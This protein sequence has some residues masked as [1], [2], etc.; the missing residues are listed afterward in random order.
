MKRVSL[1]IAT[2][3]WPEALQLTLRSVQNQ[4]CL[5]TEVLIAD[6]GSKE[7]TKKLIEE[8]K[9]DF[10]VPIIHVWHPDEGFQ[11]AKIRNRAIAAS[12]GNYI[13]QTDGDII[14]HRHFIK[15]HLAT[16]KENY[17]ITGSRVLL[18]ENSSE[19][20]L[21]SNQL[22][23]G[24][25]IIGSKNLLNTIRINFIRSLFAG[26]Y[27]QKG[28]YM[29]YVKGCNMSFWKKDLIKVNGYN[30]A[31]TGWGCEDRELAARLIKAG[32]RK[33]SLKFGGIAFHLHHQLASKNK[34][35][36]QEKILLATVQSNSYRSP[37]GLDQYLTVK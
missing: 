34:E 36:E 16:A 27:K 24:K 15:D 5:P 32:V 18:K 19:N 17:F 29:Y 26:R 14:L 33:R 20:I 6:D 1:I 12:N 35:K 9:K 2:Y 37:L 30:E 7:E 10:P 23:S 4:S 22:F 13:I 31:M 21:K 11:L 8:I 28:K 3:N 25:K